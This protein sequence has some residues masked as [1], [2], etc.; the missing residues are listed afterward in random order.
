MDRPAQTSP[1]RDRG[2]AADGRSVRPGSSLWTIVTSLC[3]DAA[4][5]VRR[6]RQ[7]DAFEGARAPRS[8]LGALVSRG[9]L[10]VLV[11]RFG[12]SV[13]A[14]YQ[15][16]RRR[17]FRLLL[18]LAYHIA[19]QFVSLY[20]KTQIEDDTELGP[21]LILSDKGGI[22][23]GARKVGANCIIHE[24]V[25]IG[26][27]PASHGRPTLGSNVR[28][29]AHSVVYGDITIGNGVCIREGAVVSRSAPDGAVVEGNP[30]RIIPP[31]SEKRPG[32]LSALPAVGVMTLFSAL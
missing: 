18:R 26:R 29:G 32:L 10:P 21:G 15:G 3:A 28:V 6:H 4:C 19:F 31:P 7:P 30:A 20:A 22:I 9:L 24:C 14:L 12:Y 5:D 25:T 16:R 11:H 13:E 23:L 2:S 27:G 8:V 17:P 1:P